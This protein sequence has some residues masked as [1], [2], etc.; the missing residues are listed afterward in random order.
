[1]Q[2]VFIAFILIY[3]VVIHE[4]A[5]GW[6]AHLRGDP[7]AEQLGRL[8]LNP[9][10][11]ID[12]IGTL[13]VPALLLY[14]RYVYGGGFLFGWAKP[15][16]V[17]PYLLRNP[18]RDMMLIGAAGPLSNML[19]AIGLSGLAHSPF[20]LPGTVAY[21]VLFYGVLINL[22]LA[23]FNLIPIPPLDGSKIIMGLLSRDLA[24]KY[25]GLERYGML[26]FVI[27]IVT[28]VAG[29]FVG[30]PVLLGLYLL[31]FDLNLL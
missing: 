11:H 21:E 9:I 16:P 31:G 28:G 12:L 30:P 10:P 17:N 29:Y 20:V 6:V 24:L 18:R 1:M 25:E 26:L 22:V 14:M 5:H 13:L 3:A 23:F 19:M 7:T 8:T 2:V 15:V 4:V 27:L